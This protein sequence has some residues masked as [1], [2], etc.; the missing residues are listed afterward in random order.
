MA[1]NKYQLKCTTRKAN[2]KPTPGSGQNVKPTISYSEL[3]LLQGPICEK[4]RMQKWRFTDK[5]K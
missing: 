2:A 1:G 3:F 4:M 5:L